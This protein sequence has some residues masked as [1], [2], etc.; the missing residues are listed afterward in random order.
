MTAGAALK[1]SMH[2]AVDT[3]HVT[4]SSSGSM[5]AVLDV[6]GGLLIA[7]EKGSWRDQ[8][9]I[10]QRADGDDAMPHHRLMAPNTASHQ[11]RP[12]E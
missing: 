5:A 7:P 1:K 3:S 2:S 8:I 11:A 9:Y 6:V 10:A 12:E 4:I